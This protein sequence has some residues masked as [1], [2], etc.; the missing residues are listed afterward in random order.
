MA[1]EMVCAATLTVL[2]YQLQCGQYRKSRVYYW[3]ESRLGGHHCTSN[4]FRRLMMLPFV[5][6]H[7]L[8]LGTRSVPCVLSYPSYNWST[9]IFV[10]TLGNESYLWLTKLVKKANRLVSWNRFYVAL[11]VQLCLWWPTRCRGRER[12]RESERKGKNNRE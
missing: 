2:L 9:S 8:L 4:S 7:T 3:R 5:S 12:G 1:T 11:A 6:C 10:A